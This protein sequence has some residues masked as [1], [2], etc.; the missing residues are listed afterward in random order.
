MKKETSL[1]NTICL[2]IELLRSHL[3][4]VLQLSLFQNLCMKCCNTIYRVRTC[5][6]KM[7]HLNLTIIKDSHVLNL[8]LVARI[9][10]LDLQYKSSVDLF[11]DLVDTRK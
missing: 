2:I 1:C 4:E 3:I 8:I 6:S 7:C 11:Y 5:D 9:H 10:R